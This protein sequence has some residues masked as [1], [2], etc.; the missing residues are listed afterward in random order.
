MVEIVALLMLGL[1]CV[2]QTAAIVVLV[3]RREDARAV[4]EQPSFVEELKGLMP[5]KG[6]EDTVVIP[7]DVLSYCDEWLDDFAKEDC[8]KRAA[9]HFREQGDWA[10]AETSLRREDGEIA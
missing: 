1:V 2:V 4:I 8:K 5:G 7:P 10:A 6:K 9:M 3:G